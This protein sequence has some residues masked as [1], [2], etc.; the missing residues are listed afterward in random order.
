MFFFQFVQGNFAFYVK[1]TLGLSNQY[2]YVVAVLLV[3][4]LSCVVLVGEEHQVHVLMSPHHLL[5]FLLLPGFQYFVDAHQPVDSSSSWKEDCLCDCCVG[6][7]CSTVILALPTKL[8]LTCFLFVC[9][10]LCV[11]ASVNRI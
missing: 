4:L 7:S 2:T 10:F 5:I 6:Q 11:C 8:I 3:R 1:Y 9:F